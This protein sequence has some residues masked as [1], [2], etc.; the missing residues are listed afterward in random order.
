M[1]CLLRWKKEE[2]EIMALHLGETEN[3]ESGHVLTKKK[4]DEEE[5]VAKIPSLRGRSLM[6]K[7]A[8]ISAGGKEKGGEGGEAL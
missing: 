8:L 6:G 7:L 4:K 3:R 1:G 5:E 2:E